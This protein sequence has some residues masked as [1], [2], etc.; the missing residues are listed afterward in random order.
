MLESKGFYR[1]RFGI[2]FIR[3]MNQEILLQKEIQFSQ[4]F[5]MNEVFYKIVMNELSVKT[6]RI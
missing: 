2:C 1:G 3:F 4:C 6:F 5:L